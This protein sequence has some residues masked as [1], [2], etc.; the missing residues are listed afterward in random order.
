MGVQITPSTIGVTACFA[1]GR[2]IHGSAERSIGCCFAS[3]NAF[4]AVTIA[5]ARHG[6]LVASL[7]RPVFF[8][9]KI[10]Y[11]Y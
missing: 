1:N 4:G 7:P 2:A 5:N 6:T 3:A 9:Q 11:N 10:A 8:K